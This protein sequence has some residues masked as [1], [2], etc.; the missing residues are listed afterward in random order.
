LR[1]ASVELTGYEVRV[2]HGAGSH[3]EPIVYS[4]NT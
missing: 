1:V 3:W 2:E 4:L